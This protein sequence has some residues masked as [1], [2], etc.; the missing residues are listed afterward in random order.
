MVELSFLVF[1]FETC[2]RAIF[3]FMVVGVCRFISHREIMRGG[4]W[5]FHGWHRC[6]AVPMWSD[7]GKQRA[8]LITTTRLMLRP[9]PTGT[10]TTRLATFIMPRLDDW[11]YVPMAKIVDFALCRHAPNISISRN[12]TSNQTSLFFM[13]FQHDT[14]YI[15]ELGKHKHTRRF[16]FTTPP[17]A[18]PDVP[19]TFGVIGECTRDIF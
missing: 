10:T 14:E 3:K 12:R 5:S 15:Y 4:A 9:P 16:S 7:I 19:Y 6:T 1:S 2:V 17:K 8:I 13:T 11:R 18:G